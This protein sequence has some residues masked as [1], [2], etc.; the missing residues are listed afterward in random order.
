MAFWKV[1]NEIDDKGEDTSLFDNDDEDDEDFVSGDE[2]DEE[3]DGE[4]QGGQ[5]LEVMVIMEN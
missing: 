4:G 5:V 1:S 2:D 3:E